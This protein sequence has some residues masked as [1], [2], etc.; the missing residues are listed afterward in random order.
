LSIPILSDYMNQEN[1]AR[2]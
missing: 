2:Y 1:S